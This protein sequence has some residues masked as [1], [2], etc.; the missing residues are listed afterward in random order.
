HHCQPSGSDTLRGEKAEAEGHPGPYRRQMGNNL[1]AA[2][3][4]EKLRFRIRVSLNSLRKRPA[5]PLILGGAAVHR[6]GKRLVLNS[7]LAAEGT[8]LDQELLFPQ[9]V[10][11][12]FQ[13]VR[14][15]ANCLHD[16][17][18]PKAS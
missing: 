2:Q 11:C 5:L 12:M 9:A 15:V 13:E 4:A 7:A 6:C 1:N 16:L 10:Q 14:S 8:A 18:G 17:D 3:L